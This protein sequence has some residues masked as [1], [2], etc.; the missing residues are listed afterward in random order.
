MPLFH[1]GDD[2]ILFVHIPKCGGTAIENAFRDGGWEWGYLNEPK[3]TGYN[4]TPCNPQHYHTEL[5]EQLI[6]PTENCTDQ[7]TIVRNP[8]TRLISEFLWQTQ[9]S[10]FVRA[11]GYNEQF[12]N[13]LESFTIQRLKAYKVNEAQYLFN[14][15]GFIRH[16]NSFVFDNHM[17]PQHHFITDHWNIYWF[18]EM[19]EKFW[20]EIRQKYGVHS[21]GDVNITLDRKFKRPTKHQYPGQEFKDLFVEIYYEDCKLFGYDLPF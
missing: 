12:F 6:M 18:E 14:K 2:L 11:N 16:K 19:D 3:K 5:I 17:R 10:N 13:A 4:E 7:F 9:M 20:P 21:P 1:N 8:Y 15:E